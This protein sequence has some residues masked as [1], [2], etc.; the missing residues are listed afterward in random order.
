[1]TRTPDEAQTRNLIRVMRQMRAETGAAVVR[2]GDVEL[3]WTTADAEADP[4]KREDRK[5]QGEPFEA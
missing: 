4:A 5:W 3:R 1:M 2:V